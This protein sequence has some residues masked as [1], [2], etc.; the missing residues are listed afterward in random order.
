MLLI[1]DWRKHM[2]LWQVT[3]YSL[4]KVPELAMLRVI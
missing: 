3:G 2:L 4:S 1:Y